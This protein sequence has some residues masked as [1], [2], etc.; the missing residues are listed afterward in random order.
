MESSTN[1]CGNEAIFL[2]HVMNSEPT[3]M[4]SKGGT[5]PITRCGPCVCHCLR[6]PHGVRVAGASNIG[7]DHPA[8]GWIMQNRWIFIDQGRLGGRVT[9]HELCRK[10]NN[11]APLVSSKYQHPISFACS[12]SDRRGS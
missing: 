3:S 7:I 5:S 1:N 6:L 9:L 11:L 2:A 12:T 8:K 10:K 4:R